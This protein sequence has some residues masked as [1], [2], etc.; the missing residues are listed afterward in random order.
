M[1]NLDSV[2]IP[3]FHAFALLASALAMVE[4][5]WLAGVAFGGQLTRGGDVRIR[6]TQL[7]LGVSWALSYMGALVE[8]HHHALASFGCVLLFSVS[9]GLS[10][11]QALTEWNGKNR[12]LASA[13]VF[14]STILCMGLVL[15]SAISEALHLPGGGDTAVLQQRFP[16]LMAACMVAI[17]FIHGLFV[18]GLYHG[19]MKPV[20]PAGESKPGAAVQPTGGSDSKAV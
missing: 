5:S 17:S 2:P 3:S 19:V 7:L 15:G 4:L 12:Y 14:G 8:A 10:L 13:S 6:I 20:D 16:L 1:L 9:L 11:G 18:L